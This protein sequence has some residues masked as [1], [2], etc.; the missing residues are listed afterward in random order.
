VRRGQALFLGTM[1]L[2]GRLRGNETPLPPQVVICG[3][4]HGGQS[5]AASSKGVAPRLDVGMLTEARSRRAGP[6]SA[7]DLP[8]FCEVLRTGVDPVSVLVARE[9]PTYQIDDAACADLWR[10]VTRPQAE[11]PPDPRR[12]ASP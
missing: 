8:S 1:P 9:M 10:F 7:Y 3:N 2:T 6:P 4:C 5:R 12:E 11:P